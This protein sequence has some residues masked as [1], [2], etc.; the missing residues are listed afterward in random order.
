MRAWRVLFTLIFMTLLLSAKSTQ[1]ERLESKDIRATIKYDRLDNNSVKI[2]V[3]T[4]NLKAHARGGISISFPYLK[5]AKRIIKKTH[6]GF[7]SLRSYNAGSTV[8]NGALKKRV[9]SKYLLVEG[10]SDKW[11][12]YSYRETVIVV[13]TDGLDELFFFVRAVVVA[14]KKESTLPIRNELAK[15]YGYSLPSDDVLDQQGYVVKPI[16][17][18]LNSKRTSQSKKPQSAS[19]KTMINKKHAKTPQLLTSTKKYLI[20][21]SSD[22]NILKIWDKPTKRLLKEFR[23]FNDLMRILVKGDELFYL[24]KDRFGKIDLN[25]LKLSE[26]FSKIG[27][28]FNDKMILYKN[29]LYLG[30]TPLERMGGKLLKY[31]IK[32]ERYKLNSIN[33]ARVYS[34]P[35]FELSKDGR[36]F[37]CRIWGYNH[38]VASNKV[39]IVHDDYWFLLRAGNENYTMGSKKAERNKHYPI[40][41]DFYSKDKS[42]SV[43]EVDKSYLIDV[44]QSSNEKNKISVVKKYDYKKSSRK[45]IYIERKYL[46]NHDG[47]SDY[48][49]LIL[50]NG[51]Y[52]KSIYFNY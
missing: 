12:K 17:I 46:P 9:T 31:N 22:D 1:I 24:R 40:Q 3:T 45:D 20:S 52:R 19:L 23:E 11:Y 28:T 42:I 4:Q 47:S 32:R 2:T 35:D 37:Y 15:K 38:D 21:Y 16:H 43:G 13:D 10:W 48:E 14:N 8:W 29:M 27:S 50:H 33:L 5:D 51:R 41:S 39:T 49:K 34:M 26:I 18:N 6:R 44:T 7:G 25:N 30:F 36:F